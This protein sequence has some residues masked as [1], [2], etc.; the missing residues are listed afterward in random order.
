MKDKKVITLEGNGDI[1][2]ILTSA[3][4]IINVINA[5]SIE[6]GTDKYTKFVVKLSKGTGG[7]GNPRY[8]GQEY[9]IDWLK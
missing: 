1:N 7:S 6:H 8:F 9:T 2:A 4:L 3:N 5:Q